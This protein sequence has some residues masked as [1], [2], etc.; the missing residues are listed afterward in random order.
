MLQGIKAGKKDQALK[1]EKGSL[2]KTRKAMEG[3]VKV[4][5]KEEELNERIQSF[6]EIQKT[7]WPQQMLK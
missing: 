2:K 3:E 1:T 7:K 4:W 5:R 6:A